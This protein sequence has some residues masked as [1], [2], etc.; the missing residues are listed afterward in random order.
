MNSALF[1]C[2]PYLTSLQQEVTKLGNKG[3][4]E[5]VG[6]LSQTHSLHW[7]HHPNHLPPVLLLFLIFLKALLVNHHCWLCL[8]LCLLGASS[9]VPRGSHSFLRAPSTHSVYCLCIDITSSHHAICDY[10][11]AST[12]L[13]W[14]APRGFRAQLETFPAIH[15][16][17]LH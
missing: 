1:T 2:G 16:T 14:A 17:F 7:H 11:S 10:V 5:R 3:Q 9:D 12:C 13:F 15:V 6:N 4:S 8:H